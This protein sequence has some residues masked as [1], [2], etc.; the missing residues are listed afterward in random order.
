MEVLSDATTGDYCVVVS[1]GKVTRASDS[2][3]N[4]CL[5]WL[6]VSDKSMVRTVSSVARSPLVT[7]WVHVG[8]ERVTKQWHSW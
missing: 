6:P 3:N 2:Q 5:T 4:G 7:V 1:S 8:M